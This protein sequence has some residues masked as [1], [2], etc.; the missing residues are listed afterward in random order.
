[1]I[2]TAIFGGRGSTLIIDVGK[3][4]HVPNEEPYDPSSNT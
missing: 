1:M 2:S 3:I 4:S